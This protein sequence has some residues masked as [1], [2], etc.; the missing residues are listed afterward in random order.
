MIIAIFGEN[1]VGKTTLANAI[2]KELNARV[3]TGRDYLRLRKN[4]EYAKNAF[5]D[6]LKEHLHSEENIIYVIGERS[7]LELLP[8]GS[9]KIL[10]TADIEIIKSRFAVRC[11]GFLPPPVAMMLERKH[12]SWDDVPYDIH[13]TEQDTID[14]VLIIIKTKMKAGTAHEN[15]IR[16]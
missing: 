12:G 4:A 14:R 15:D 8:S 13:L 2:K 6:L 7:Q 10:L 16:T 1:C 11:G 5:R 9:L 3:F